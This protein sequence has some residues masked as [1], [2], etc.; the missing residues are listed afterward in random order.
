[1]RIAV[2]G[3]EGQVAR[4][5]LELGLSSGHEIIALARPAL[6]LAAAPTS[7]ISAVESVRPEL[8]VSAA[9]YTAVDKAESEP[10]IAR[11][12]NETAPLA[13]ARAA[14]KLSVPMIHLSTDYVFDGSNSISYVEDDAANPQGVYG[15]TKFAGE[16][17][18]LGEHANSVVL[19]TSWVY[20]PFGSNFVKT[21]LRLARE[22]DE[23]GVVG[24]QRGT[25]T[26]AI[27][28]AEAVLLIASKLL[29]SPDDSLRGVFHLAGS[30][31]ASWAEFAR[32]IFAISAALGGP[33][34]AVKA[35]ATAEYPTVAKRPS[36]SR[37]NSDRM[38]RTYGVRL[39]DWRES[40]QHVVRRL[41]SADENR[42][43][44]EL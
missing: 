44:R 22:R 33:S 35:I 8:I 42:G 4:S 28:I 37:L 41:V 19:R 11:A 30:G 40:L 3:R 10:E 38:A 18:V 7:I 24:D 25:P 20:S 43:V 2:T 5:L 32:E 13:I 31:E 12:A 21:M 6:D 15:A 26:S 16:K 29:S 23:I 14:R 27:D 17:A 34:A 1:M 36:N 9:A 39:P